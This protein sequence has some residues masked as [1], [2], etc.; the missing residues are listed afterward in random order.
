MFT[1]MH[2]E[3]LCLTT[4]YSVCGRKS[5][6]DDPIIV[7][8][9]LALSARRS[10]K[11]LGKNP[12]PAKTAPNPYEAPGCQATAYLPERICGC[13]FRLFP[14]QGQCPG[15]W[16][17]VMS[18]S[19]GR[20]RMRPHTRLA[21]LP[22]SRWRLQ[23]AT[24][25]SSVPEQP[26]GQ[27]ILAVG[28][29]EVRQRLRPFPGERPAA[30][31]QVTGRPHLGKI[32]RRWRAQAPAEQ[33]G[34][35]VGVERVVFGRATLEG[36]H[37]ERRA[38]DNR[39]RLAGPQVGEPGPREDPCDGH[40]DRLTGGPQGSEQGLWTGC[41]IALPHAVAGWR[42]ETDIHAPGMQSDAAIRVVRL[43]VEWPEDSSSPS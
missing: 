24:V 42:Q 12:I 7:V 32:D 40:D 5:V 33:P 8:A 9:K 28:V 18:F 27:G 37:R 6:A 31:E 3:C 30:P 36:C 2:V 15:A 26:L 38:E 11:A 14:W 1:A 29:L 19:R 25:P 22:P 34:H 17:N 41:Q 23:S 16:A 10:R 20:G 43:G 35:L 21:V 39:A 4:S 13:F